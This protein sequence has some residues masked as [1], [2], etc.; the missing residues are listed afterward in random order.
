MSYKTTRITTGKM[1]VNNSV[2]G[3]PI[4]IKIERMMNG[5]E[6]MKE[7]TPLLFTERK[8]GVRAST[9]IRTDRWLVAVEGADKIAKSYQARREERH[10]P[11]ET[12]SAK[13]ET[14]QGTQQAQ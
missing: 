4:E 10:K 11:K 1:K 7:G 9:N 6:P 14:T 3:E 12:E 13:T 5:K 8:E 2:E